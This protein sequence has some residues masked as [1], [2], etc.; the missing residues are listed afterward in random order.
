M[1][2]IDIYLS[3]ASDAG[4]S[5]FGRWLY[6]S[7]FLTVLTG[8]AFLAETHISQIGTPEKRYVDCILRILGEEIWRARPEALDG[9]IEEHR[10]TLFQAKKLPV[11]LRWYHKFIRKKDWTHVLVPRTRHP[12]TGRR[13][14]RCFGV[15]DRQK[16]QCEGMAGQIFARSNLIT[17]TETLPDLQLPE[18]TDDVYKEYAKL[19]NDDWRVVKYY[20]Y[21]SRVIGG[22][23]IIGNDNK[24]GVL[25]FDSSDPSAVT[26]KNLSGVAA[27][28]ALRV[29]SAILS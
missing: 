15:H 5:G 1:G 12:L 6:L 27:V 8:A 4:Q 26:S 3:V 9:P 2:L 21:Q 23:T 29:L 10:I 20:R 7:L 25:V 11:V 18:I 14:V 16:D 13:P 22:L 19:A 28:R 17:I 24:W